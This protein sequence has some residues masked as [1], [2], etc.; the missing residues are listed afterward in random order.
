[1]D[2]HEFRLHL[3]L[4]CRPRNADAQPERCT[5]IFAKSGH[6][7]G[8]GFRLPGLACPAWPPIPRAEA[9]VRGPALRRRGIAVSHSSPRGIGAEISKLGPRRR[10]V[11]SYGPSAAESDLLPPQG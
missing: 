3:F 2:V 11:R 9:L 1:M 10:S 7:V 8:L 5:R 4:C 6:G